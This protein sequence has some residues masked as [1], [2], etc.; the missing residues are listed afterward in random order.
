MIL[1]ASLLAATVLALLSQ[2]AFGQASHEVADEQWEQVAQDVYQSLSDYRDDVLNAL[3]VFESP[4]ELDIRYLSATV[5]PGLLT[6]QFQLFDIWGA[7]FTNG[8][9][10]TFEEELFY[11]N[12]PL[13]NM[14][15]IYYS[16]N[17]PEALDVLYE[18]SD[19]ADHYGMITHLRQGLASALSVK[20]G[21]IGSVD[22]A[23]NS[24]DLA[25][26]FQVLPKDEGDPDSLVNRSNCTTFGDAN[27]LQS[28]QNGL[29]NDLVDIGVVR[30]VLFDSGDC[31]HFDATLTIATGAETEDGKGKEN[32][33]NN[34]TS[35]QVFYVHS[36]ATV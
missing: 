14:I 6:M 11:G 24:T 19:D 32:E 18:T 28:L 20:E 29:I 26:H 21:Q 10:V 17:H 27:E 2:G 36:H 30:D 33:D 1:V 4:A 16:P 5:D 13:G 7:S 35:K 12:D 23:S 31:G 25:I 8:E 9:I 34:A 22:L 15:G 3:G